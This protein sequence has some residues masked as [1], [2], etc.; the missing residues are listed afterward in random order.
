MRPG[1][2]VARRDTS[3]LVFIVFYVDGSNSAYWM[4]IRCLVS[5]GGHVKDRYQYSHETCEDDGWEVVR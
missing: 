3:D 5:P 4:L 2:V 1:D